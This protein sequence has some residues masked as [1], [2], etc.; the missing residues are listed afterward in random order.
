MAA[1]KAIADGEEVE[2][3]PEHPLDR[4]HKCGR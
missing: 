2:D 4:C 3:A 1:G